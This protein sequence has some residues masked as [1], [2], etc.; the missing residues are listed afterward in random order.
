M[1]GVRTALGIS[2]LI[3]LG[4]F[5]PHHGYNYFILLKWVVFLTAGWAASVLS[6]NQ[7]PSF[8]IFVAVAVLHNPFLK[9]HFLRDTWLVLDGVTAA[10]F[11][12]QAVRRIDVK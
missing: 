7:P 11:A 8:F 3:L 10:W 9:F 4:A 2:I 12:I 5:L 6:K 1:N